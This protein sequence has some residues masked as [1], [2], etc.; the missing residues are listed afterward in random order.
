ML[1]RFHSLASD[2]VLISQS[3]KAFVYLLNWH[4]AAVAEKRKSKMLSLTFLS[5]TWRRDMKENMWER[6]KFIG[7]RNLSMKSYE[8]SFFL[9]EVSIFHKVGESCAP[10]DQT[11]FPEFW[12]AHKYYFNMK[13]RFL[14]LKLTLSFLSRLWPWGVKQ[15]PRHKSAQRAQG[16]PNGSRGEIWPTTFVECLCHTHSCAGLQISFWETNLKATNWK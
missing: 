13:G 4:T 10:N 3:V 16:F 5:N 12:G 6:F 2:D 9:L 14:M 1:H 11:W 15:F 7:V 8:K